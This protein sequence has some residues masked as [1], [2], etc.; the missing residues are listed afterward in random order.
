MTGKRPMVT[1]GMSPR[2]I[3]A[4]CDGLY[5]APK[6]PDKKYLGPMVG[7]AGRDEANEQ[8]VGFV[9]ANYAKIE[10]WPSISLGYVAKPLV[11]MLAE[12]SAIG[13]DLDFTLAAAPLGGMGLARD[14]GIVSESRVIYLEKVT[15][16]LKTGTS[17]EQTTLKYG[18]H[19]PEP[20][21]NIVLVEDVC[22]NFSTT[23]DAIKKTEAYGAKVVAIACFLNRSSRHG[24]V[25]T[26]TYETRKEAR[27]IPVVALWQES[28]PEYRQV[29]LVARPFIER[30][31]VFLEPKKYW[32]VL[33]QRMSGA[34]A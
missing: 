26:Y 14:L 24:H 20:G 29:D 4:A 3:L 21:E 2:E 8:F 6:G 5:E 28:M 22:N 9:Y 11:R 1:R 15:T 18:R 27:K 30:G 7:Y 25:Y 13:D 23:N 17:R 16:A 34:P 10:Q 32:D 31:E 19:E 33:Q 12:H